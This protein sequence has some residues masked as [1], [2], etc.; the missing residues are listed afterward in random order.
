MNAFYPEPISSLNSTISKMT[1]I[2]TPA[3]PWDPVEAYVRPIRSVLF[4]DDQFPTFSDKDEQAFGE[5]ERARALWRACTQRGWLCDIDNSADWTTSERKQR[6]SACDLL[7]LDYHLIAG[8]STPALSII[9]DLASSG[10]PNLVVVYTRDPRPD[11]VLLAAASWTRGVGSHQPLPERLEELEESIEWSSQDLIRFLSNQGDWKASLNAACESAGISPPEDSEC[12][13][14]IE[15]KLRRDFGV[16]P[17]Q[18]IRLIDRIG[19][20]EHRWFQCGNLFLVVVSKPAEQNVAEEAGFFL[21][22]LEEAVRQW[23]PP[24]L[25]CLVADSRRR[26]EAGAFRDDVLLPDEPLQ[27]G[28]LEYICGSDDQPERSWRATEIA[29]HLLSRRSADAAKAL[30]ETLLAKATAG[31]REQLTTTDLLHLNAFLCSEAFAHHHLRVGTI[32]ALRGQEHRYWVC[33]T[34]ACDM[35]P[36]QPDER[37]NPWAAELDPFRPIVALRL[38]PQA[39]ERLVN[40][41]LKNAEQA[42]HLFFWDRTRE[43]ERPL[44][45]ACFRDTSDPNPQLEHMIAVDRAR[46]QGGCVRLYRFVQEGEGTAEDGA[47]TAGTLTLESI[48]CVPVAQLRAPYAERIV[49]VVGGHVSRIGVNFFRRRRQA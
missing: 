36:R 44:V 5:A 14:L 30:G 49:H 21:G 47:I 20:G 25:A 48:E 42:R 6:L 35:V 34:P 18:D 11:N 8:N 33:V 17:S 12:V 38:T 31:D 32:F 26:V 27:N 2:V 23:A 15:R 9:R 46:V 28:L 1:D 19:H 24:W 10:L 39:E 43:L 41:A 40:Q 37:L 4:I 29:T 45:A 16:E 3:E 7:V 13:E 22:G